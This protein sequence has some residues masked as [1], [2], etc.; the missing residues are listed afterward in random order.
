[1]RLSQFSNPLT[2]EQNFYLRCKAEEAF[3]SE[4]CG[5]ILNDGSL[6]QVE[7]RTS[8]PDEFIISAADYA[9]YGD[10][11]AAIWHTHA[12]F[13]HFSEADIRSCKQ[14]MVPFAM[15]D[16]G[17][18]QSHW[19]DPRQ[20]TGLVGRPWT[21]GIYDCYSAVRDWYYQ[22]TGLVMGDYPRNEEGEWHSPEFNLFERSF[23]REGFHRVSLD[24]LKRGDVLLFRIRNDHTCN[25]V[26]VVE[27]AE[28]GLIYQHLVNRLSGVDMY[29]HW[30][31][32]TT[33]MAVRRN[34]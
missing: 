4:A 11:I 30:L 22:N 19:L 27:D 20:T 3:P 14:L 29:G 25:H 33:Y 9:R 17:S 6:V 10:T 12:N 2:I 28:A 34:P 24:D 13:P 8:T 5:F 15:W 32:E 26:A 23:A 31:R 7:N 21:Y 16:C 18:S 1:M